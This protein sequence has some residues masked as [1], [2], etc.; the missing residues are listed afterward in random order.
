MSEY[1]IVLQK[2]DTLK[3]FHARSFK[4][5]TLPPLVQK[6]LDRLERKKAAYAEQ[7]KEEK[8]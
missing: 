6:R 4:K 8:Q 1:V 5:G 3:K 2:I 7:L